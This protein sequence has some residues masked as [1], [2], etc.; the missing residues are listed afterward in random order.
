MMNI[1]GIKTFTAKAFSLIFALFLFL[2]AS[3]NPDTSHTPNHAA[4]AAHAEDEKFDTKGQ[5]LEHVSDSYGWHIVGHTTL[6]LPVILNTDKGLETFSSKNL[7]DEHH[8]P[9]MYAGK[10]NYMINHK[11]GK[12]EI[13]DANGVAVKD[14]KIWDFSITKNIASLFLSVIIVLAIFLTVARSYKKRGVTSAPKGLQ[15]FIEPLVLFVRDDVAKPNIGPKY[16]RYMPFLLTIF[17]FVWV[18]N[19]LGLIPFFPFG[20]NLSG[21]IAFTIVLAVIVFL[22]VNFSGNKNYWKHIFWMPGV[23]VPMKIFLAPIE[24]M[25]VFTKPISLAIRLFANITAGHILVLALICL[26]FVFKSIFVGPVAVLFAGFIYCIELLVA[27]LQAFI[28]TMLTALYIG[29]AVEEH[30]H[31]EARAHH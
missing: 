23:P 14:A 30:H 19:L 8:L 15:S 16:G 26:V 10:N 27:F 18:N 21:N 1:F 29:M 17:F 28:F 25:G 31:D 5:I 3:A 11:T 7:F 2:G 6:A 4:K 22:V 13:V 9:K 20:A 12:I 24:L